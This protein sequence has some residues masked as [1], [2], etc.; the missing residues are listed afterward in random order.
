MK[1]Q[2][3]EIP[4]LG[5]PM[6][7]THCHL[8][9]LD[10][11]DLSRELDAARAV[12]VERVITI[13]VSPENLDTVRRIAASAAHIFCTQGVHPHEAEGFSDAVAQQMRDGAQDPKVVAIGEI[14][15]DYFYDHADR[16]VQREVFA[17]QL[18]LAAE[19]DLP[20]VIHSREADDDMQA[21][22]RE[23][24]GSLHRRGVIHSFSSGLD[25]AE[26]AIEA[27]FMLGYNGMVTFK[28]AENVREAVLRTPVE[29]ILLETDAPYLTPVPYRGTPN[30]PRFLPFVAEKIADIKELPVAQLLAQ[31]AR[32]TDQLFFPV[33][34][35]VQ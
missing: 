22:L 3:R 34:E 14:G 11:A 29:R 30:A 1:K 6:T 35:T 26:F 33:R 5:F 21:I 32:N 2:R 17:R 16:Q 23:H 20:V 18:Q 4:N 27:G 25:L 8:D 24:L 12:G 13:S 10:D 9:Y 28:T 7:E 15:L 31:C 19:L